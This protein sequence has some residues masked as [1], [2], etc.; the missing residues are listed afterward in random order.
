MAHLG[1]LHSL[2]TF[3]RCCNSLFNNFG[4]EHV[5]LALCVRVLITLYFDARLWL[6]SH[7]RYRSVW[8]GFLYTF[9]VNVPSD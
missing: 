9:V 4:V 2:R 3:S 6:L 7:C 8:V 5:V 1:Y